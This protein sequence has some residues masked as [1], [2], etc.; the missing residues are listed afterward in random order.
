MQKK[1]NY[2]WE[3]NFLVHRIILVCV[4]CAQAFRR[5]ITS[6][7]F[8]VYRIVSWNKKETR[9]IRSNCVKIWDSR[10]KI[11]SFSNWLLNE[12]KP[13]WILPI[14]NC[15][16]FVCICTWSHF[17]FIKLIGCKKNVVNQS[18]KQKKIFLNESRVTKNRFYRKKS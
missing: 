1:Q 8:K 3:I 13:L 17:A 10:K 4:E 15:H 12:V 5:K 9:S 11:N 7:A 16:A 14:R 2:S 18:F 6:E